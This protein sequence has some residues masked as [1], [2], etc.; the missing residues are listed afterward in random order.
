MQG[1]FSAVCANVAQRRYAEAQ[2]R[3]KTLFEDSTVSG[4][5]AVF[6][7]AIAEIRNAE[8]CLRRLAEIDEKAVVGVAGGI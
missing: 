3:L 2:S 6:A 1:L 7:Q 4:N 8:Y 5:E